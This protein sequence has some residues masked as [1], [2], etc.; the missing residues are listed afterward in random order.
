MEMA[1][2]VLDP[3][4]S[5]RLAELERSPE[6]TIGPFLA[7]AVEVYGSG[8]MPYRI[9]G[10]HMSVRRWS[11][12]AVVTVGLAL[13]APV[14]ANAAPPTTTPG[15]SGVQ[16]CRENAEAISGAARAER[17]FGQ[18]VRGA[19]PIADDNAAFFALFCSGGQ[20]GV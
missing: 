18:T 14:A 4:M 17:P 20:P 5:H 1:T 8:H 13:L 2:S 16:G 3:G 11:T 9:A 7:D 6:R 10:G 15:Q 12:G 19:A